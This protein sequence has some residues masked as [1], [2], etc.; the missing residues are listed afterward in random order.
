MTADYDAF[1]VEL[2]RA[3]VLTAHLAERLSDL[4]DQSESRSRELYALSLIAQRI[5]DCHHARIREQATALLRPSRTTGG[6]A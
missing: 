2:E 6:A 3:E 4:S 1:T 5:N